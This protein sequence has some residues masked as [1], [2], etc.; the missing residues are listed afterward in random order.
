[1]SDPL[2]G[3]I[4]ALRDRY[5]IDRELGRGSVAT[6]FRAHDVRHDRWVALK[7]LHRDLG[8]SIGGER[9]RQAIRMAAR[10]QH[11]HILTVHDSGEDG[12]QLWFTMP[13]IKGETLADRIMREGPLPMA[14][15]LR[16]AREAADALDYAH[17][18]GVIHRDIKPENVLLSEGHALVADFGIARALR[19]SERGAEGTPAY[20]SP[21][22]AT[23]GVVDARADLYSLGAV[24]YEM[25]LGEPPFSGATPQAVIARAITESPRPLRNL[26]PSVSA[27]VE[28]LT[29]RALARAPEERFTTA[30]ELGHALEEAQ[31]VV[32]SGP[33]RTPPPMA[34]TWA[35]RTDR[36]QW[37][38]ILVLTVALLVLATLLLTRA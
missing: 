33:Q 34:V 37:P 16:I 4:E 14:D 23:G 26:R 11:P 12:G 7:L 1:M 24:L 13:F 19:G 20:M 31:A 17:R 22:Q 36:A 18:E 28:T 21:E 9:F 25:L 32:R 6:V 29:L 27:A 5:R 3:L 35:G 30:A 15:A 2:A 38:L 10:L 8:A